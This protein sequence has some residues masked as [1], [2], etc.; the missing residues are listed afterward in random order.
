MGFAF[1]FFLLG[2]ISVLGQ[3]VIL[4]ETTTLFY[5]NEIFY[6]LGLGSWMFFVGLGSFFGIKLNFLKGKQKFWWLIL[7]GI[8]ALIVLEVIFL[9][10]LV[11]NFVPLGE[12]PNPLLAIFSLFCFFPLCF[13]VGALFSLASFGKN[14][15]WAY[16]WETIG[17]AVGG[18]LFSFY[19]NNLVFR[20][21]LEKRFPNL[22]LILNSKYQQII[23]TETQGQKNYFLN[24]QLAFSNQETFENR[25]LVSLITPFVSSAKNILL[26]GSPGLA[27]EI[28]KVFSSAETTFLEIDPKLGDLEKDFLDK[29]IKLEIDDPKRFLKSD[30]S[31][32]LIIFSPGNPQTLLGNRYFSREFFSLINQKLEKKGIFALL[33]YLPTDY[34]S[35]EATLFGG[36]VYQTLENV[37][38]FVELLNPE[39]QLLFLVSKNRVEF[40]TKK[41]NPEFKDYFLYQ[42]E[43]PQRKEISQ[44]LK[45]IL[46]KINTD[47]SPTTFFYSQLFW[48]TIFSA[49]IPKIFS[50]L[51][52][53]LPLVLLLGILILFL[54]S[55]KDFQLGLTAS[56]SSFIL[57]SLEI[58][59]VFLFQIKIG[60]LYSQISLIFASILLGIGVGAGTISN[61][62]YQISNIF[63]AYFLIFGILFLLGEQPVFWFLTAF[64]LGVIGGSIFAKI[65]KIYLSQNKHSGFIYSFDLFG[66]VLGAFSTSSLFLPAFGVKNLLGFLGVLILLVVLM[67]N[68]KLRE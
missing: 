17:F 68:P 29:E 39:E 57:L 13:L 48:Q 66:G 45:N 18:L 5:G 3:A 16:V 51:V 67:I 61:I 37:F 36:S 12:L 59:L 34:Q 41:I 7:L 30:Q 25:Q 27:N 26:F 35:E 1:F 40:D 14:V 50:R 9:R 6:G 42:V 43:N 31:W 58:L 55:K 10:W 47:F 63:L 33:F 52:F 38:P 60:Y 49:K 8:A 15:N 54:K 56:I 62:K 21:G 4:R 53:I 11:I 65:N 46:I 28:K 23:I 64:L 2:L 19:L 24:G 32:D 22:A 44:K 20:W